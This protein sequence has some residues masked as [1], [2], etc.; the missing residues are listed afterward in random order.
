M[1]VEKIKKLGEKKNVKKL[2]SYA[3]SKKTEERAAAAEALGN[4]SDDAACNALIALLRDVDTSVGVKAAQSLKKT[5]NKRAVEHLRHVALNTN[6][7]ALKAA[8]TDAVVSLSS[9]H[10]DA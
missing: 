2:V 3:S 9:R 5:N 1:S 6:D 10:T 7:A 8:C 4:A